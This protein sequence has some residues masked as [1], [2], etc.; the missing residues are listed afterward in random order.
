MII[1]V[2]MRGTLAIQ[3]VC[4]TLENYTR[5]FLDVFGSKSS[6]LRIPSTGYRVTIKGNLGG[7]RVK[8][9]SKLF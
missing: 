2:E 1:D 9:L 4:T 7:G 3:G 5:F 6:N 8:N